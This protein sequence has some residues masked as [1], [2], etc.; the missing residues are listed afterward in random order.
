MKKKSLILFFFSITLLACAGISYAQDS[1]QDGVLQILAPETMIIHEPD[2]FEFPVNFV[3]SSGSLS[4]YALLDPA[5]LAGILEIFDSNDAS[6]FS[7]TIAATDLNSTTGTGNFIH[8]TNMAMVTVSQTPGGVDAGA[9]NNPPGAANV[10]TPLR[11]P[12]DPAGAPLAD[13]CDS[14]MTVFTEPAG[15]STTSNQFTMLENTVAMDRGSYSIGFGFRLNIAP[16]MKQ[17]YYNGTIIF[18]L[19]PI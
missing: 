2:D 8:Y 12:W 19:I 3:P 5:T 17:D 1:N 14:F 15:G 6:G 7:V 10:I 11:C 13:Q 16:E 9:S 4:T 18:T